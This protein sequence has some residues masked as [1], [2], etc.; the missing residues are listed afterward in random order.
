MAFESMSAMLGNVARLLARAERAP[1]PADRFAAVR[2]LW[3]IRFTLQRDLKSAAVPCENRPVEL[4]ALRSALKTLAMEMAL[5]GADDEPAELA[6]PDDDVLARA[7]TPE[8]LERIRSA[9]ADSR[10]TLREV[11]AAC[12]QTRELMEQRARFMPPATTQNGST[13]TNHDRRGSS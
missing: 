1:D 13:S 2:E 11:I 10:T 9:M 5:I 6:E 7:L 8:L 12:E 3:K 4:A